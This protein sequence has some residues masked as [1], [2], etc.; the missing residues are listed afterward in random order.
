[1]IRRLVYPREKGQALPLTVLFL[2]VL[3]GIVSLVVDGGMAYS[4]RRYM[5]NAA[6]AAV[7]AGGAVMAKGITNDAQ[8]VSA[9]TYYAQANK[10]NSITIQYVNAA[11]NVLGQGGTGVVPAGAQGLK[12][13]AHYQYTPGFAG[14]L[15]LGAFNI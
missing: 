7:L 11:G 3:L 2:F 6:D 14:V 1:M 12:I 9:A 15:G 4:Y 10:A 13:V 8:I 5:Q